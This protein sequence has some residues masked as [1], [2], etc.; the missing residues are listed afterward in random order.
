MVVPFENILLLSMTLLSVLSLFLVAYNAFLLNTIVN[1][2]SK[3][4]LDFKIISN[5]KESIIQKQKSLQQKLIQLLQ[6][7][8]GDTHILKNT[9]LSANNLLTELKSMIETVLEEHETQEEGYKI[10][11]KY[12]SELDDGNRWSYV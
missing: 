4:Q 11:M 3:G 8:V 6:N 2:Y 9:D 12:V 1:K 5:K 10:D 7:K